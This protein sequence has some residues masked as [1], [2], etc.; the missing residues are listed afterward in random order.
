MTQPPPIGDD[1]MTWLPAVTAAAAAPDAP[2][3]TPAP[4]TPAVGLL[5]RLTLTEPVRL[6]IYSLLVIVTAG[7]Q[8]A[9]Y[10]SGQW[11][12]FSVLNGAVILG[13]GAAGEGIRASVY[14]PAGVIR[15]A[16]A[17]ASVTR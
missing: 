16:R 14:S 8:L 11:A 15:A 1:T 3:P 10:E 13:V 6:W 9:G 12:D 5:K 17:A 4:A 7:L 2:I